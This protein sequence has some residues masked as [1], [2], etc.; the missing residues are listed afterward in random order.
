MNF[1]A[2]SAALSVFNDYHDKSALYQVALIN[3]TI[4]LMKGDFDP[5]EEGNYLFALE[6]SD[7]RPVISFNRCGLHYESGKLEAQIVVDYWTIRARRKAEELLDD[8]CRVCFGAGCPIC[9]EHE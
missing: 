7:M 1:C 2:A 9:V 4:D 3:K 5:F 6:E 8:E